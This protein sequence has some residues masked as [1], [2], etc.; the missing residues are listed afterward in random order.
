M[1]QGWRVWPKPLIERKIPVADAESADRRSLLF[2][3]TVEIS[4]EDL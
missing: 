3:Q 4:R 1:Q 2:R